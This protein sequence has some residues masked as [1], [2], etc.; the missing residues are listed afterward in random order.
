MSDTYTKRIKELEAERRKD[1]RQAKR[2][3]ERRRKALRARKWKDA[4]RSLKTARRNR[5]EAQDKR[6]RISTLRSARKRANRLAR[7]ARHN[8]KVIG[9]QGLVWVNGKQ[10]PTWIAEELKK[11]RAYGWQGYVVSGYRTPAYSESLCYAMCGR[12]KCPGMCAGRSSNHSQ[13][14]VFPHG[15]VDVTDY[16]RLQ[17]ISQ[18]HGLRIHNALPRDRV[19]FSNSGQ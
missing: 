19:H 9:K 15:A 17:S 6:Q 18:K 11:A 5:R 3:S 1:L 10:V 4:R 2:A 12:P 14:F 16:Y 8:R 7:I 13:G